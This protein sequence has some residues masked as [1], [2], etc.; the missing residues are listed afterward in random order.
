VFPTLMNAAITYCHVF[1][2]CDYRWGM[3]WIT[4]FI[5]TLGTRCNY[6]AIAD[7]HNSQ[8]TIAPTKSFPA[9]CVFAS[10]SL[11]TACNSGESS[12]SCSQAFPSPT[13]VQ[14]CLPAIPSTELDRHLF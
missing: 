13:L 14:N 4:G 3:D 11:A 2:V 5:D 1:A 8:F 12:A 10:G 7:V 6:S 9:C